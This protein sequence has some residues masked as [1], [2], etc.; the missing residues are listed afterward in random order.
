M[1]IVGLYTVVDDFFKS[2]KQEKVWNLIQESFLWEK[3]P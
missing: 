1:N 3:R 2:I